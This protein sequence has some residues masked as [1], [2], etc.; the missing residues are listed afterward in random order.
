[1]SIPN[2][3][4]EEPNYNIILERV[5]YYSRYATEKKGVMLG[6]SLLQLV[7]SELEAIDIPEA[8]SKQSLPCSFHVPATR[9]GIASVC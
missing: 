3:V 9:R 2:E 8:Q 4:A 7:T 6:F 5:A 1:V